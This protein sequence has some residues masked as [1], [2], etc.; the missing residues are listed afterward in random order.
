MDTLKSRE[1]LES[2]LSRESFFI[3]QNLLFLIVA[4]VT[5]WGTVYPVIAEALIDETITVGEPYFNRV[6]GP[7]LFVIV[8]IMGVG[9]LIPWRRAQPKNIFRMLRYPV[10]AALATAIILAVSG[11]RQ[12]VAILAF[13][14]CSIVVTGILAEWVRGSISRHKKGENYIV[15]WARL[16]ANNR[17]R[18]GGYVVHLAIIMLT[19]GAIGSSFFNV[20]RDFALSPGQSASLGDYV[21]RYVG[22]ERNPFSDREEVTAHLALSRFGRDLGSMYPTRS[23]YPDF[24][25]GATK[26]AIRSTPIEDFYVVPS[27]FDDDGGAVFRVYINPMVWWMWA[28]GPVLFLGTILAISPRRRRVQFPNRLPIQSR[29]TAGLDGSKSLSCVEGD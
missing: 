29:S 28:S 14:T 1:R 11:M 5:L 12:P 13:A 20:Q 18:Y 6:N 26:A 17:P 3:L 22:F 9:P 4:F 15:A 16:V 25:I 2:M 23:F 8:L 7:I 10:G 24:R 27:E 19:V 21:F